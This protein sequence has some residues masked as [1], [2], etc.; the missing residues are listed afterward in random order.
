MNQE[1]A[2]VGGNTLDIQMG[3][4]KMLT[5]GDMLPAEYKG[6]PGNALIAIGLGQSMGLSPAESLY[7]I[8]VIQGR[9]TA[10]AELIAAN[11]RKAG[12]R[13]RVAF[14]D[15]WAEATIWRSDDPEF[16]HTVRRDMAWA[17]GMGLAKNANYQKNGLTMLGWR[18]IS[19]C[20]RLACPEALYGVA[21][22][23]DEMTDFGHTEPIAVTVTRDED[24]TPADA[25][26]AVTAPDD[27][28]TSKQLSA[29]NAQIK[30][31]GLDAPSYLGIATESA[32]REI[33]GSRDLTSAEAEAV[34]RRLD[35]MRT[36]TPDDAWA[37]DE[38]ES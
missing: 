9:P 19:A 29:L 3:Y 16:P 17:S 14:G 2:T 12:H 26:T 18:A 34:L 33:A 4:A 15:D 20:A 35:D 23:P 32:G 21:Y 7:R 11:V 8:S 22:V 6:K 30:R 10:S 27:L 38:A 37:T 24:P 31:L 1:L 25:P 36:P 5:T 13:L 28:A